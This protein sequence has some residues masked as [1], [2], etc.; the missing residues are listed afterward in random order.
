MAI[1]NDLGGTASATLSSLL[2]A[3]GPLTPGL[4]ITP[5]IR[6]DFT[7]F[8]F[9]GVVRSGSNLL[10]WRLAMPEHPFQGFAASR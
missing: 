5:T 2:P 3:E 10:C 6:G 7:H 8:C 9:D 1:G 4:A